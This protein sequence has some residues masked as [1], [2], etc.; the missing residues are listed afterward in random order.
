MSGDVAYVEGRDVYWEVEMILDTRRNPQ[1]GEAEYLV[2]WKESEDEP[3]WEPQSNLNMAAYQDIDATLQGEEL[4]QEAIAAVQDILLDYLG[5]GVVAGGMASVYGGARP[6]PRQVKKRQ[7]TTKARVVALSSAQLQELTRTLLDYMPTLL[8]YNAASS[9]SILAKGG[10]NDNPDDAAHLPT[11]RSSSSRCLKKPTPHQKNNS[12][13]SAKRNRSTMEKDDD[14]DEN[15]SS[16]DFYHTSATRITPPHFTHVEEEDVSHKNRWLIRRPPVSTI[17]VA[18]PLFPRRVDPESLDSVILCHSCKTE[19]FSSNPKCLDTA[20]IQSTA[21]DHTICRSCIRSLH[22]GIN[23]TSAAKSG[24]VHRIW[25]ACP[26]C[27]T[28]K[29][30]H[31]IDTHA[32]RSLCDLIRWARQQEQQPP[33]HLSL[34]QHRQ[35]DQV[36]SPL[37]MSTPN[38]TMMTTPIRNKLTNSIATIGIAHG[39]SGP[40]LDAPAAGRDGSPMAQLHPAARQ[41]PQEPEQ[42]Q[43]GSGRPQQEEEPLVAPTATT[44]TTANAVGIEPL[45]GNKSP[46]PP[47]SQSLPNMFQFGQPQQQQH[48]PRQQ[49]STVDTTMTLATART[50]RNVIGHADG[51]ATPASNRGVKTIAKDPPGVY[52]EKHFYHQ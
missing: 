32:N 40:T 18:A 23:C 33:Q 11:K 17:A 41:D 22:L 1:T 7:D 24:K 10:S 27:K 21:C 46:P 48:Q 12:K 31:G 42:Q 37:R 14:D 19:P 49:V 25:L 6:I 45:G 34:Q 2:Q 16:S 9:S 5:E 30:F 8:H 20:P 39:G 29:A 43:Q 44:T 35:G 50:N 47:G 51:G 26:L 3:T 36:H 13:P 52:Y 28:P 38:T 15:A 4:A